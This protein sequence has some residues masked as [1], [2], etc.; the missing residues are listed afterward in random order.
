MVRPSE[1]NQLLRGT[2][3]LVLAGGRGSRLHELT[4]ERAKPAVFFGGK[5]RIIDFALSNC[6]N[7]GIRRIGVVTQYESHSLIRHLQRGW[8]F[9]RGELNETL[10]LWPAR[11][12]YTDSEWYRGTADA[13][14][15]NLKVIR[16]KGLKH[17]LILAGDH[18]YKMDYSVMLGDHVS[19]G[20]RC[21]VGCI[22]VPREQASEFGVM[23]VDA[24][25]NIDEF[26][27]KP[28]N[29][30]GM[31][32][33]PDKSL[34]S[35]GIYIFDA[36]Y[37]YDMLEKDMKDPDSTHD[38]GRDVIPACV[39]D[40]QAFAH[41]FELSCVTTNDDG[42][43]YWRDVG[44]LDAFWEA[45]LELAQVV[46]QLDL[47]STEWPIWTYQFHLPP[48]KFVPDTDGNNNLTNCS[49]VSAGCV[50]S[51]SSLR[52]TVLFSDVR[53]G[54]RCNLEEAVVMPG[55]KIGQG[56]R[57][58]RVV[59]DCNCDVPAGLVIGEDPA[60]DSRRF[61]RSAAGITLV[62]QQMLAKLA[63]EPVAVVTPESLVA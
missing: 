48:A 16:S 59:I 49:T 51:G 21:T 44:T 38:F 6:V 31:P 15:Q 55:V 17:V 50:V 27:E 9:L 12:K 22:S 40:N 5:F 39:A 60:E 29:P 19:S 42:E 43:V 36:E 52:Q 7:S 14:Y 32:G 13:V 61:R 25:R 54:E 41:P 53:V 8:S 1:S 24:N 37:L 63:E 62:T 18:I 4:D 2:M 20:R 57:L 47:Y 28:A 35:M 11:Q 30:P 3:A 46:P 33:N 34:A 56:C 26:L 45:N 23:H 58:K 10:D